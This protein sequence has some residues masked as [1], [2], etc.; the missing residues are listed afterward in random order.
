LDQT[1]PTQYVIETLE[2]DNVSII[3]NNDPQPEKEVIK[4][5]IIKSRNYFPIHAFPGPIAP[6]EE[7]A[8]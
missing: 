2:N 8:K 3:R 1:L 7:R 6:Q 4:P 5:V